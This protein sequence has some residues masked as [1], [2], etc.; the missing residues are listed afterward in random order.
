MRFIRYALILLSLNLAKPVTAQEN[1]RSQL[2]AQCTFSTMMDV[3]GLEEIALLF[4]QSG[5][6]GME[7]WGD[8]NFY[9]TLDA[10]SKAGILFIVNYLPLYVD[11]NKDFAEWKEMTRK[12]IRSAGQ[13][14]LLCFH[15]PEIEA[16]GTKREIE[17]MVVEVL[18]D[19][20]DYAASYGV[21]VCTYPHI[22]TYCETV[23]KSV[24]LAKAV[25][26]SNCGSMIT[27]CHLLK[28]EGTKD[29]S[30]TIEKSLDYLFAV[31][32]SGADKGDT[33]EMEW[34]R[35]IQPLGQGSF[36]TYHF[37]ELLWDGGY[38]GPVGVQYYGIKEDA[39]SV[40]T[41]SA[42]VWQHYKNKYINSHDHGEY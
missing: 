18:A 42:K 23:K 41:S 22:G 33:Q 10:A 38:Q 2:Y 37:L 8:R 16:E 1:L 39:L 4:K 13:G 24:R 30:K 27:L 20:S 9:E 25:D 21:K 36:D 11:S 17:Q 3:P 32:I 26:H 28:V 31:T 5:Y 34:D 15:I 19:M 12:M 7:A 14:S 35:L 6:D 40:I 29:I